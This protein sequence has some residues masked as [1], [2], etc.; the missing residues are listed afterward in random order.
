MG[1]SL[2][3]IVKIVAVSK[4]TDSHT[5]QKLYEVGQ[6][7]F[8]ESKVQDFEK[9]Y[10]ELENLPI[11]WHFIGR[12]QK[13]KVNKL[14]SLRPSL[15][16][17]LDSIELAKYLNERLEQRG[18]KLNALLQINSSREPQKAGV[19][20][21]QAID[22]YQEILERFPNIRLK[23]VMAIGKHSPVVDEVRQSFREVYQ[24]YEKL[25]K[26]GASICSMGM[27]G[28]FEIAISE[29]SN[30]VRLGSILIR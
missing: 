28:D 23:G 13:N 18:E 25:Q 3:H 26:D 2:H 14:I 21:E 30:M 19:A 12:L 10:S 11:E 20:P 9:K 7:A 6:R 17:S 15:L 22:V 27:S 1:V 4:Y 16:Q 24:I 8:G 5:I 29:G